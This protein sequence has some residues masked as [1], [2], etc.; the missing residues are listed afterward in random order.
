MRALNSLHLQQ[1][2][3]YINWTKIISGTCLK[4][5]RMN[6]HI[7]VVYNHMYQKPILLT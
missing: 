4:L 2:N 5:D 7:I 1:K 3:D 6:K